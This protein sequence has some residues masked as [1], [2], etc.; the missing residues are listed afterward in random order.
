M[1]QTSTS[2][3]LDS[4]DEGTKYLTPIFGSEASDAQMPRLRMNDKPVEPRIAYEMIKEYLSIEGNATQNLTTFCQTYM[5][6]MATRIMAET[7]EKNA[8]DKDEYPIDVY[9]RQPSTRPEHPLYLA[10]IRRNEPPRS[11]ASWLRG[12]PEPGFLHLPARYPQ[13]IKKRPN[14]NGLSH[15]SE[16]WGMI[17]FNVWRFPI[18]QGASMEHLTR[19]R[20]ARLTNAAANFLGDYHG[21]KHQ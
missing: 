6:P 14:G 18:R 9:K 2:K 5:E 8:I 20:L 13:C 1:E 17:P 15:G 7:M 11:C 16:S 4:M 12:A 10:A 3:V 19:Q 21:T